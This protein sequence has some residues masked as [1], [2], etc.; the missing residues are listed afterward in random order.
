M[1]PETSQQGRNKDLLCVADVPH[2]AGSTVISK[3]GSR[4]LISSATSWLSLSVL[5]LRPCRFLLDEH[6]LSESTVLYV[7]MSGLSKPHQIMGKAK[8]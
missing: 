1:G 8:R 6:E 4:Y 7:G 5:V 2:D 3:G